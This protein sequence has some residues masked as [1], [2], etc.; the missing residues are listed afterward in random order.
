MFILNTIGKRIAAA[1]KELGKSQ[2][3]FA[4]LLGISRSVLSQIEIDRTPPPTDILVKVATLCSKD[5][6]WLIL[7]VEQGSNQ[8]ILEASV[9]E[10]KHDTMIVR[11]V[12]EYAYAGYTNGFKDKEFIDHLPVRETRKRSGGNYLYFIAAGDSM[13]YEGRNCIC[14]GDEL[15]TKELPKSFW[16]YK[17]HIP[18]IFVIVHKDGILCKQIIA[19]DVDNGII[20]CHPFNPKEKDFNLHLKDVSQL[21]YLVEIVRSIH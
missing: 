16:K 21:W 18:K 12:D 17:I 5:L 10:G 8:I 20:T 1:R 19:H 7:G 9:N 6:N 3:G 15:L 11:V 14:S 2:E 4:E 13:E